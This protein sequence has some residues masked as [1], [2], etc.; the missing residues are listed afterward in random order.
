M[1]GYLIKMV[2]WRYK[3]TL[4]ILGVFFEKGVKRVRE[5]RFCTQ[6]SVL[7]NTF[8]LNIITYIIII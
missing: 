2:K 5:F 8:F 6:K 1:M 4:M 3:K 7:A